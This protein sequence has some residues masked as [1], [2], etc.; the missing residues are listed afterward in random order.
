MLRTA[1]KPHFDF[2]TLYSHTTL[3][4]VMLKKIVGCLF[5]AIYALKYEG[6]GRCFRPHELLPS[7]EVSRAGL[8]RISSTPHQPM[9][10]PAYA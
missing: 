2:I 8:S 1:C 3:L 5:A 10:T 7:T 4:S 9:R 6:S